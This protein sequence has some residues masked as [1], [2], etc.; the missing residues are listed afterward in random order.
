MIDVDT[1]VNHAICISPTA[2]GVPVSICDKTFMKPMEPG[3]Y[4]IKT[5]IGKAADV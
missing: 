4:V 2:P 3:M 1:A 5:P